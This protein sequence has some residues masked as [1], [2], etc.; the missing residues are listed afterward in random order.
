[1]PKK[2]TT[3]WLDQAVYEQVRL[4]AGLRGI[5]IS[6]CIALHM[7]NSVLDT[8]TKP[9]IE[10]VVRQLALTV[11]R[12]DAAFEQRLA[13]LTSRAAI[14]AGASRRL[15]VQLLVRETSPDKAKI[16]SEA[17]WNAAVESHRKPVAGLF[18]LVK[19]LPAE[20][21]IDPST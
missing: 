12:R 15:L 20:T 7:R 6:E 14:E 8:S 19:P 17:A 16:L 21:V 5:T 13:S 4:D 1:M 11:Q 18:E 9:G 3:T 10:E 2:Q